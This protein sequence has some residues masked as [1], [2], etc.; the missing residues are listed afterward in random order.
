MPD[1]RTNGR[2]ADMHVPPAIRRWTTRLGLA[3]VVAA[4]IGYVPGQVLRR[5]PRSVKLRDQLDALETEARSL[6][7][8]NA[9]LAREI[10]ALRTDIGAVEDRARV[11]LGMVY[12]DEIVLRVPAEAK[13]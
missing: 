7:A 10:D 12:P 9:T 1:F 4:V 2:V 6:A 3:I 8:G 13:P 5:D 11:D